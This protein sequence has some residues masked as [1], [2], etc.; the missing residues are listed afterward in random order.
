[1]AEDQT[2]TETQEENLETSEE[3]AEKDTQETTEPDYKAKFRE[4]Q[5]EAIRLSKQLKEF[6]AKEANKVPETIEEIESAEGETLDQIVEKKVQERFAPLTTKQ[7]EE[8]VDK[9]LEKHQEAYDYLKQ[10]EDSYRDVPGKTTEEKLENALLIAKKDIAKEAGKREMAFS[11]Y[12][13]EMAGASGG[14]ASSSGAEGSLP[15]LTEEEKKVAKAFGLTEEAYA[16][17][18]SKKVK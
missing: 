8:R 11:I 14:G 7:E 18:K 16:K 3:T 5:T 1:M 17:S 10:I 2:L 12:Q 6:K 15:S 9:W 13:K 4:S